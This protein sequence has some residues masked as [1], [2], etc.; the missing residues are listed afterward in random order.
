MKRYG[1]RWDR[2]EKCWKLTVK[3]EI[4]LAIAKEAIKAIKAKKVYVLGDMVAGFGST[5]DEST[6]WKVVELKVAINMLIAA[7]LALVRYVRRQQLQPEKRELRKRIRKAMQ[8]LEQLEQ[9][10]RH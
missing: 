6:F 7:D 2:T 3:D 9:Q 5:V 4:D 8:Q 10:L 1:F